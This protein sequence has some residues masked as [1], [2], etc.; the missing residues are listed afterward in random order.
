MGQRKKEPSAFPVERKTE[1]GKYSAK[2]RWGTPKTTTNVG[3]NSVL[4][5]MG[6]HNSVEKI[7]QI[8]SPK[9]PFTMGVTGL[10]SKETPQ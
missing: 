4:E 7:K 6:V 10:S 2:P 1:G 8:P 3:K 5:E 9:K